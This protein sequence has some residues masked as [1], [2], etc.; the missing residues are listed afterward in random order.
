MPLKEDMMSNT[1]ED[2]E[3]EKP[4]VSRTA[5]GLPK[6]VPFS[7]P[8]PGDH[9]RG[10]TPTPSRDRSS[11]SSPRVLLARIASSPAPFSAAPPASAPLSPD[12]PSPAQLTPAR[13]ASVRPRRRLTWL[14]P[15]GLTVA[16]LVAAALW[17][18]DRRPG[19]AP[20][21]PT[22]AVAL[23]TGAGGAAGTSV[24]APPTVAPFEPSAGEPTSSAGTPATTRATTPPA[25]TKPTPAALVNTA[26]RNLALKRPV[27]A[28][29][30]QGPPWGPSY[31]VDGVTDTRWSSAF[32][33]PQWLTVDLGGR[34][35]INR[36]EIQWEHAY[37]TA[38]RIDVS[39]DGMAWKSVFSTTQG[40]GGDVTIPTAGVIARFVRLYGTHRSS[41]YGYSVYEFEVR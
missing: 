21:S 19:P 18:Y 14:V 33:D 4:A 29:G 39:T 35:R 27:S 6:R 17:W 28:S 23:Q 9:G 15:A 16:L 10:T 41:Q 34:W 40:L 37:G 13:I 3:A 36:V 8:H 20:T 38:Y 7:G 31:A 24:D 32:K 22:G 30:S 12:R 26:G 5:A 2:T 1:D 11:T 25:T